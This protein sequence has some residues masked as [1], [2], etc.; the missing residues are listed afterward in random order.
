MFGIETS[1]KKY[2]MSKICYPDRLTFN[3]IH[4]KNNLKKMKKQNNMDWNAKLFSNQRL[5]L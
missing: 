1:E 3:H 5:T 4:I 2:S